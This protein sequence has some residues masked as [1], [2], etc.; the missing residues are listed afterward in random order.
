MSM[1]FATPPP[2][3]DRRLMVLS[4]SEL[5]AGG[6]LDDLPQAA[7]LADLLLEA[8][9]Q[10]EPGMAIDVVFNG[11]TFD[12]LKTSYEDTWPRH[13]TA[14]IALAKFS[15]I[16]AAH[17]RFFAGLRRF[18]RS[19]RGARRMFFVVGNHDFDLLFPEVQGMLRGLLGADEQSVIFPGMS[20]RLGEVHCEHGSQADR[21][22]RIDPE[23]PFVTYEGE[24]ILNLPWGAVALLDVAMPLQPLLAFHDRLKPR[25]K[26]FEALPELEE[27]F[28]ARFWRYWTRD[29]LRGWLSR[30]DPVKRVS[31]RM[32]RE[33]VWR[34]GSKNIQIHVDDTYERLV[35][36]EGGPRV[37]CVGHLHDAAWL[38]WGGAKLLKG[39]ALR[40]E[41][42]FSPDGQTVTMLPKVFIDIWMREDKVLRS[43][44]VE[45]D[46]PPPPEGYIPESIFDVRPHLQ[47]LLGSTEERAEVAAAEAR[48][49][50]SASTEEPPD[51]RGAA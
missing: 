30:S 44:L 32:F 46:A 39:A 19:D 41:F 5:G 17:P 20:V 51:D 31:W 9:E 33:L 15:R 37:A 34:F 8:D 4:D 50:R 38:A 40:N 16:A 47:A 43:Q 36:A 18:L 25:D 14:D 21:L 35:R 1:S 29:Y 22:F 27:V 28:V 42:L 6:P 23:R 10:A 48:A 13:I 26:V 11:D 12:L 2:G 45:F 7:F 24:R 49:R 3:A